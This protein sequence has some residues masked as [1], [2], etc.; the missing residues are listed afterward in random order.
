M[1]LPAMVDT[2]MAVLIHICRMNYGENLKLIVV[3]FV[4]PESPFVEK[5]FDLFKSPVYFSAARDSIA[6]VGTPYVW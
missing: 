5:Y 1:I 3:N 4:S 2:L 6:V